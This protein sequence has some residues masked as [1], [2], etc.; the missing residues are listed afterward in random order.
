MSPT[1]CFK[2]HDIPW[3]RGGG[4][5]KKTTH[6]RRIKENRLMWSSSST[7][8]AIPTSSWPTLEHLGW[9]PRPPP[10]LGVPFPWK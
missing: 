2:N 8:P 4:G 5:R 10:P 3:G 9:G 1:E 7:S 6:R